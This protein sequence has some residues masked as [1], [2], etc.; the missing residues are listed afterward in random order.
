MI[1]SPEMGDCA[2]CGIGLQ[3]SRIRAKESRFRYTSL[4]SILQNMG[5]LY[6]CLQVM[7]S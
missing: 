6:F 1:C 7:L 5:E 4:E 2:P 3:Y